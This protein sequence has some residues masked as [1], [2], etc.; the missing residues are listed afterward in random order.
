LLSSNRNGNSPPASLSFYAIST[1]R[2]VNFSVGDAIIVPRTFSY[3]L[4]VA[5]GL[6]IV[7]IEFLSTVANMKRRGMMHHQRYPF[8]CLSVTD[9]KQADSTK[10]SGCNFLVLGASNYT[11]D[12]PKKAVHA[13]LHRHSLWQDEK[14]PHSQMEILLPGTDLLRAYSVVLV[15]EFDQNC[16]SKRMGGA[17]R[18]KI[19]NSEF[20]TRGNI[21]IM[22]Q[23]CGA[24]VY[25]IDFLTSS[26]QIKKGLTGDQIAHVKSARPLGAN[27]NGFNT[28]EHDLQ[29]KQRNLLVMV[30]ASSDVKVGK[31]FLSQFN[32]KCEVLPVVS[33]QWLLDSIG[34]FEVKETSSYSS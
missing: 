32:S 34:E 26:K 24:Q 8:P 7:D 20:C 12:A 21:C 30:K 15:G 2:D 28:L 27:S 23:L 22:L 6:P 5:C 3:Y 33:C 19:N 14:G 31:D 10:D 29:H 1:A 4:S 11:W 25:D 9:E 18:R 16:H 17:K 13:A